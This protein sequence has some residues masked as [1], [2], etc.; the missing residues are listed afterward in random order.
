MSKCILT[1]FAVE[2]AVQVEELRTGLVELASDEKDIDKLGDLASLEEALRRAES[3]VSK[4]V[5]DLLEARR[6]RN[7]KKRGY[8]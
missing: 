7:R 8:R 2:F 5:G 3:H 6:E 4:T 1:E